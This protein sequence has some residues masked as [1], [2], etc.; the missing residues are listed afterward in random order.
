MQGGSEEVELRA[1][2]D[3]KQP[4]DR[5]VT[6]EDVVVGHPDV[7]VVAPAVPSSQRLAD[8]GPLRARDDVSD[9]VLTFLGRCDLLIRHQAHIPVSPLPPIDPRRV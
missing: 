5:V 9:R 7:L 6:D 2:R 8:A 3:L 1:A 4:A